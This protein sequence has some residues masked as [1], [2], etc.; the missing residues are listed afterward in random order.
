[1]IALNTLESGNVHSADRKAAA[2]VATS[3]LQV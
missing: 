1:M 2:A 3:L